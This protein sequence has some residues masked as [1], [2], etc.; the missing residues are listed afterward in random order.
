MKFQ[1]T[2]L[3]LFITLITKAQSFDF[4]FDHY[5]IIVEDVDASATF[6]S[7]ILG[8]KETPHP[9]KAEGFRWFIINGNS[10][11]HLIQKEVAAFDK[12]KTLH[13]CLATQHLDAFIAHLKAHH[14]AFSDWPGTKNAISKRSDGVQ[15]I[16]LQDPDGYWIEIN[17]AAHE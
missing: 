15:Q 14:I 1:L 5:S 17:D 12:N 13:L 10:Q 9:D 2:F 8:L 7:T 16:Y 4:Q 6:Y 3:L 11:L